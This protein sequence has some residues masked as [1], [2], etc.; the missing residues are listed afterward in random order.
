[1]RLDDLD[2]IELAIPAEQMLI[3]RHVSK[4]GH[5]LL[6]IAHHDGVASGVPAREIGPLNRRSGGRSADHATAL[7][8][9]PQLVVHLGVKVGVGEA[10]LPAAA[11]PYAAGGAQRG[12]EL[13]AIGDRAVAGMEH[14]EIRRA[15]SFELAQPGPEPTVSIGGPGRGYYHDRRVRPTG[16]IQEPAH[17]RGVP[18]RASDDDE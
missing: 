5:P 6:V 18:H 4:E 14:A 12:H 8:Q 15:Q 11:E 7:E 2:E 17:D 3:Y 1:M 16:E 10:P 13:V 9:S